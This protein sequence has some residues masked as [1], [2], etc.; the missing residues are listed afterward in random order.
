MR[1][2]DA[3]LRAVIRGLRKEIEDLR[4]ENV[5]IKSAVKFTSLKELEAERD[6]LAE[7]TIRLRMILEEEQAKR[8]SL[9]A[10]HCSHVE[11]SKESMHFS[12]GFINYPK[13][14]LSSADNIPN[15]WRNAR[16]WRRA[17][18]EQQGPSKIKKLCRRL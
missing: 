15:W 11:T 16:S 2:A 12:T 9:K 5:N 7:E 13:E 3:T 17:R 6:Q 10:Y 4:K 14:T 8:S 18:Q 1:P